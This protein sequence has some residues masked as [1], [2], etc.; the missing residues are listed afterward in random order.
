MNEPAPKQPD[1]TL[2][3]IKNIFI[4]PEE[5]RLRAGWRLLINLIFLLVFSII[6]AIPVV[7]A[8][9]FTPI[10]ENIGLIIMN[11]IPIVLAVFLS[12]KLIDRKT[13]RSLGLPL[14]RQALI[15][16]LIGFL[17]AAAQILLI[18]VIGWK[19]EWMHFRTVGWYD[20]GLVQT[21][22]GVF[23]WLI[24]F[25]A[26]G[27]YEELFSRGYQ[28]Q[29]LEEGLN[30]FWAIVISAGSFG[31]MHI[32]NPGASWVSTL[33]IVLAG[34]Y[35]AFAY[36]RTRSLWLAIGLHFGWNFT[37]GPVFGFP[38]SGLQTA[39]LL[40][41]EVTG[42]EI[43]MGGEFGPE[44]GLVVVP[45]LALGALLIVLFT[46]GRAKAPDEIQTAEQE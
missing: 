36:L 27:F 17:I 4:N 18:F 21:L 6:F 19:M 41:L 45:A 14:S 9:Y 24:L 12:R 30:T 38:V 2:L 37:L 34:L 15:D 20:I 16:L 5:K 23:I 29:N 35:F 11:G 25:A 26:V 42:P 44:A 1:N 32:F 33:G 13:I 46:W 40:R 10:F 7:I 3:F 22:I 43:W 8:Q 28:F 31:L 39:R